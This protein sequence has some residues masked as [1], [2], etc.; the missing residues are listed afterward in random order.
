MPTALPERANLEFL[1]KQSKDLHRA[2]AEGEA[3][4]VARI[5]Q[6]LPR[7]GRMPEGEVRAMELSLQEAQHAQ[8]A[9]IL[10][11]DKEMVRQ[12]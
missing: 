2:F 11:A 3:G 7:A 1:R 5:R 8:R 4:A 9:A 10:A 12:I 6:H